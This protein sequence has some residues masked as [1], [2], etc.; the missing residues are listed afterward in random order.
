MPDTVVD[1]YY[2]PVEGAE[3]ALRD[4]A[5]RNSE[6]FLAN[7]AA[8]RELTAT[9]REAGLGPSVGTQYTG[10]VTVNSN[11]ADQLLSSMSSALVRA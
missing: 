3:Q 4:A 1:G 10:P 6:E 9:L 5:R 8:V 2:K 11:K 7:T